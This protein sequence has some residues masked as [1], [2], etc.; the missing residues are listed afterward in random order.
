MCMGGVQGQKK[1]KKK[2]MNLERKQKKGKIPEDRRGKFQLHLF[3]IVQYWTHQLSPGISVCFRTCPKLSCS[4]C[5]PL[6]PLLC[7]LRLPHYSSHCLSDS[8]CR[9]LKPAINILGKIHFLLLVLRIM[10]TEHLV[11]AGEWQTPPLT[12]T[13]CQPADGKGTLSVTIP[14]VF[15]EQ[16]I[17][18]APMPLQ[19]LSFCLFPPPCT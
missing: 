6:P 16:A 10:G 12:S 5:C 1:K 2:H 18:N 15:Q 8:C 4:I 19:G 17:P 11:T 13:V 14:R 3:L 9:P 7:V